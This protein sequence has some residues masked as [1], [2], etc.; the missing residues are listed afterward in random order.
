V[1]EHV[2]IYLMPARSK[3]L[4]NKTAK[5]MTAYDKL[6]TSMNAGVRECVRKIDDEM[7]ACRVG[8]QL[9]SKHKGLVAMLRQIDRLFVA[10]VLYTTA[11]ITIVFAS[12]I[13][14]IVIK[15]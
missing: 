13:L 7:V 1:C 10:F 14:G 5:E 4:V 12:N 9:I 8:T 2:S 15:Q 3:A 6:L 11:I